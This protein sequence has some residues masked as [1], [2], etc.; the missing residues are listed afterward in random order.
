MLWY[1]LL[2]LRDGLLQTLFLIKQRIHLIL[3]YLLR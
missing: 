2:Q 3:L 1:L